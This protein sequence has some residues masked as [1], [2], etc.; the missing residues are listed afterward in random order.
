M[1]KTTISADETSIDE[2]IQSMEKQLYQA[3]NPHEG[4]LLD[5]FMDS[6]SKSEIVVTFIAL[7]ELVKSRKAN[8]GQTSNY[9]DILLYP[10]YE[11]KGGYVDG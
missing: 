4:C 8:V 11:D 2:K 10:V 5:A 9:E 3:V 6:Y 7:L 1:L